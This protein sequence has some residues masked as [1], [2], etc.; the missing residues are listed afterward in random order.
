MILVSQNLTVNKVNEL[1][2]VELTPK[3]TSMKV[4]SSFTLTCKLQTHRA[5]EYIHWSW[6]LKGGLRQEINCDT[7]QDSGSTEFSCS[8]STEPPR[9]TLI[10]KTT[11]TK[12]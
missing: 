1:F 8:N 9:S 2:E 3:S 6:E 4:G 5:L 10:V 11:E 7:G 12:D